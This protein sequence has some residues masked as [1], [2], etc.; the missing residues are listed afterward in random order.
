[1]K[2]CPVTCVWHRQTEAAVSMG[3]VYWLR[4]NLPKIVR[5][6]RLRWQRCT[7]NLLDRVQEV[8]RGN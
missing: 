4:A 1:M 6:A 2:P 3:H 7:C 8:I 5:L